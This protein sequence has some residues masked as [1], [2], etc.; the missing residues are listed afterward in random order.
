MT[1]L[2]HFTTPKFWGFQ[3]VVFSSD[4]KTLAGRT[5]D[6]IRLWDTKTGEVLQV[7]DG[8]F[9]SVAFSPN[10]NTLAI[11]SENDIIWLWDVKAGE[12]LRTP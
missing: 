11:G 4:S 6:Q 12:I 10:N 9:G 1:L 8:D 2:L 3:D 7:L 5:P